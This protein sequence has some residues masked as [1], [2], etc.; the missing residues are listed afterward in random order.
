MWASKAFVTALAVASAAAVPLEKR[1]FAYG[2][3]P[4]RGVNIG[5]WLVLEPW[6]TPSIFTP[7]GGSVV[8]EWTLCQ[9]VPNAESILQSH[10]SSWVSLGD[11]QKIADNGFNLVRIPIGYWAFQKFDGDPYIQGAAGYLDSAIGWAR[12]TGLKVWIDLHGAPLSQNGY[13]NSGHRSTPEW[14]T[15]DSID[16]TLSVISQ[17]SQKYGTSAYSD[18]IAGIELLNE[19]LIQSLPGGKSAVQ[20][21]YESGFSIVHDSGDAYVV[22]HDGF[23][24]PSAWDGVLTGSGTNGAIVDHHEYQV[25]T[26]SGVA[27]TP[28]EHVSEVYSSA[29]TWGNGYDKF[30]IVG[31]WSAAMTDCA[32]YLNGYG[33]GARYDGSFSGSSYIGSCSAIDNIGSWSSDYKTDTTNYISAQIDAFESKAQ[34]WIFWNFKTE[35]APEWDL[36]QLLD[37]GV[38]PS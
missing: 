24:N 15:D 14:S 33:T 30:V 23:L 20:G 21:Y 18:V 26:D 2:S 19:P 3:T 34:G 17:I 9:N 7:Y 29:N 10:W 25:F 12:Q 22:I 1:Q 5:G 37:N 36:F 38:W 16:Q 13:D 11:F 35:N 4:V 32:P 27:L 28:A 8:D 31:E 6:I